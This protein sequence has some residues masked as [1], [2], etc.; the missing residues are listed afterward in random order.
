MK[1]TTWLGVSLICSWLVLTTAVLAQE[2]TPAV[3]IP[4]GAKGPGQDY[5]KLSA[6]WWKWYLSIP[7]D[8]PTFSNPSFD[9]TGDSC[10]VAQTGNVFFLAANFVTTDALSCSVPAGKSIFF[11]IFNIECSTVEPPPFFGA[12]E[13]DM[14]ACAKCIADNIDP[15]D[16]KVVVDGQAL[17][18][19]PAD[20]P[21]FTFKYPEHWIFEDDDPPDVTIP[22]PGVGKAVSDGYWIHLAPLD[23]GPHTVSFSSVN[24]FPNGECGVIFPPEVPPEDRLVSFAGNYTLDVQG[25]K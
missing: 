13:E 11:P 8:D 22:G 19:Y 18:Y 21:L 25:K 4:P 6:R 2:Q 1:R 10:G 9:V 12:T 5:S 16:L 24:R 15:I 23:P 3:V 7:T 20:S 14:R 17:P